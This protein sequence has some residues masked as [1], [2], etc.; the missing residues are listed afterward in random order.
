M[1]TIATVASLF[2]V[3]LC[4]CANTYTYSKD[5][6]GNDVLQDDLIECKSVMARQNGDDAKDAMD[7]CMAEKGYGKKVDKYRL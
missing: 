6:A 3:F 5:G 2:C 1:K 7:Q 4:G